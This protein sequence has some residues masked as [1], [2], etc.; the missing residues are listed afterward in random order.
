[1]SFT[2]ASCYKGQTAVGGDELTT[3]FPTHIVVRFLTRARATELLDF[4]DEDDA[5]ES[6]CPMCRD[7]EPYS[8]LNEGSC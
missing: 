3:S 8:H 6:N 7:S 4:S 2:D 5:P 1:M